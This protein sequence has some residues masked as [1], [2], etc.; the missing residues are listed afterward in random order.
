MLLLIYP[1]AVV[2]YPWQREEV[3]NDWTLTLAGFL[4]TV[5]RDGVIKCDM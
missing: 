2:T 5:M 4:E 3:A 1:S